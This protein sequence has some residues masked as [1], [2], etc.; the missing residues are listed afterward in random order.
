MSDY[1]SSK[2]RVDAK[3]RLVPLDHIGPID[4]Q[5]D[6]LVVEIVTKAK[7]LNQDLAEFRDQAFEDIEAF[8]ALAAEQHNVNIGG[9]KG[10]ITMYSFDGRYKLTRQIRDRI[11]FDE[12]IQI[13]KSI[14]DEC[15]R[16]WSADSRTELQAVVA[17]AFDVDK[18]GKISVS[19]L[20]ALMRFDIKDEKW[21]RGM[22]ILRGSMRSQD[23][24]AYVRLYEREDKNGGQYLPIPL[25]ISNA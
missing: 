1:D 2:Y 17:G 10:N 15:L 12:G 14:V 3:G 24:K 25:D 23:S 7:R 6:E 11:T 20:L 22:T 21:R 18:E 13:A 8:V 4:R 19:R 16:E 9:T 5:R